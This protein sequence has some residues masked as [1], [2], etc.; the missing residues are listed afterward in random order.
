MTTSNVPTAD[1]IALRRVP[2]IL[3]HG[4]RSLKVN[5]LLD[6]ASNKTYVNSD[7]AAQLELQG[8]A[9]RVTVNVLNGQVETFETCSVNVELESLTGD[10]K[11]GV[12]AYTGTRVNLQ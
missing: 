4:D 10:V 5:A 11:L 3:K 7:V 6:D 1:F 12:A 8:K 2:V 9:E